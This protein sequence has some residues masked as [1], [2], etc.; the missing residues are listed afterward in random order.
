MTACRYE[1]GAIC[2]TVTEPHIVLPALLERLAERGWQL[3]SLVTRHASL[4]DVFVAMAGH[5]FE[6]GVAHFRPFEGEKCACPLP[7]GGPG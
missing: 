5:E 7:R 2:L 3:A 4:D 6:V 1:D